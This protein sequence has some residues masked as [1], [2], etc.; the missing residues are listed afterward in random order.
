MINIDQ[1][2]N[3]GVGTETPA[4]RLDIEG[5]LKTSG[6]AEV[7]GDLTAKAGLTV[8]GDASVHG[9][10]TAQNTV[11]ADQDVNITGALTTN[12]PTVLVGQT[13]IKGPVSSHKGAQ[14][15]DVG[16]YHA[17]T[18]GSVLVNIDIP[19]KPSVPPFFMSW[20]IVTVSSGPVRMST[21]GGY[22]SLGSFAKGSL[23]NPPTASSL[24]VPIT[25]GTDFTIAAKALTGEFPPYQLWWVGQGSAAAPT[26][27]AAASVE[28]VPDDAFASAA[29]AATSHLKAR[30]E[31]GSLDAADLPDSIRAMLDDGS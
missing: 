3:V 11:T 10:L 9:E 1:Q 13:T 6:P 28:E 24:V 29:K 22:F 4:A 21:S 19:K 31:D 25:A 16:T 5:N 27:G 7:D 30:I 2:G 8:I 15:L 26:K 18:D 20:A 17:P 12:G 14:K 23:P